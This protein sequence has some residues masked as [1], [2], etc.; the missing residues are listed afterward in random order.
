MSLLDTLRMTGQHFNLQARVQ[1]HLSKGPTSS[2]NAVGTPSPHHCKSKP[3]QPL[4]HKTPP[5]PVEE[6]HD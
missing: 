4:E 5:V 1:P 6:Q 3:I 2:G